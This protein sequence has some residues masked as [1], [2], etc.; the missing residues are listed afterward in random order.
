[1]TPFTDNELCSESGAHFDT[2]PRA[3]APF[4]LVLIDDDGRQM[5]ATPLNTPLT[6][7]DLH[8]INGVIETRELDAEQDGGR[9]LFH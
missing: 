2:E 4:Q 1:M 3:V 8:T 6:V 7:D 9:W 5:W